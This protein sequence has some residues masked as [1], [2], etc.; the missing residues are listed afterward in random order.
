MK[1]QIVIGFDKTKFLDLQTN[2][3]LE[4]VGRFERLYLEIGGKM[5][6]DLH[7]K[8]VLPGFDPASKIKVLSS[9]KDRLEVIVCVSAVDLERNKIRSDNHMSYADEAIRLIKFLRQKEILVS[10][11]VITLFDGQKRAQLFAK[12]LQDLDLEIH[13]HSRTAGYPTDVDLIVSPEGYGKNSFV[14]TSRKIVVVTAPGPS[15]GKMATC[16][17]QIY[18]EAAVG[19]MV[20]YAKYETFPVWNLPLNHPVNVAYEAATLDLFDKNMIDPYHLAAYGETA[21]NYNRDVE[22]FP[23]LKRIFD[24]IYGREIYKSPTD[25]GVNVI[26]EAIVDDQLV[27]EAAKQEIIRR[28]FH[29][30]LDNRFGELDDRAL[31]RAELLME[32]VGISP[33]D[34]QVVCLAHQKYDL[35]C[36]QNPECVNQAAAIEL[37]DGLTAV[38]KKSL[39]LSAVAATVLNI[40]KMIAGIDDKIFLLPPEILTPISRIKREKLGMI[41][42][43]LS[44]EEVIFALT[45]TATT[46]PMAKLVLAHLDDLAGAQLHSTELL[47]D[48]DQSICRHLAIDVTMGV[49]EDKGD[50]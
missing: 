35:L 2:K 4:R 46:N 1:N 17:S 37:T 22:A 13:F 38:G 28:Y 32:N 26:A 43:E 36:Q 6:D 34:R 40:L 27:C 23:V 49:V 31:E 20:G 5:I 30:K 42:S 29:A 19:R 41:D 8:R 44:L 45:V 9:L 48:R 33:D 39:I 15:S 47:S 10:S 12:K 24:R 25:M 50:L 16:L 18:H 21:V 11:V 3:I 14:K 7:A